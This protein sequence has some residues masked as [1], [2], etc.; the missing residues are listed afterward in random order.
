MAELKWMLG[1]RTLAP[2]GILVPVVP[3]PI[4]TAVV[5][6]LKNKTLP[7]SLL[8]T[9]AGAIK[10]PARIIYVEP[11]AT[12]PPVYVEPSS[13]WRVIDVVEVNEATTKSRAMPGNLKG[14][15][16]LLVLKFVPIPVTKPPA[17]TA[18]VPTV[19][20]G[21][22]KPREFTSPPVTSS[23]IAFQISHTLVPFPVSTWIIVG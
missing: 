7:T 2:V 13:S 9:W 4:L 1:T 15:P 10:E 12:T 20:L 14:S 6:G 23:G 16:T 11:A 22:L 17:P 8:P 19:M 5:R 21:V 18:T 3:S